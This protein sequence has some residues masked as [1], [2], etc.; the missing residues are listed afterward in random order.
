MCHF[1]CSLFSFIQHYDLHWNIRSKYP[2]NYFLQLFFSF[3]IRFPTF[4]QTSSTASFF[5]KHWFFPVSKTIRMSCSSPPWYQKAAFEYMSIEKIFL[6]ANTILKTY[7][8]SMYYLGRFLLPLSTLLWFLISSLVCI[9][10]SG[11]VLSCRQCLFFSVSWNLSH[12]SIFWSQTLCPKKQE[13]EEIG[14]NNN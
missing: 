11:A 1:S 4:L 5:S 13:R 3:D 6:S 2:R 10:C 9:F 8:F 12:L 14:I 7:P